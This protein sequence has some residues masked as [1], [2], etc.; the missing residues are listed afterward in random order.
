MIGLVSACATT[1][2]PDVMEKWH[3]SYRHRFHDYHVGFLPGASSPLPPGW[4]LENLLVRKDR[5]LGPTKPGSEYRH[6]VR[7]D[8]DGDGEFEE[9][10]DVLTYDLL[11]KHDKHNGRIW[12]STVALPGT[13][14]ER[15]LSVLTRDYLES[16]ST[17]GP[18]SIGLDKAMR[19][20]DDKVYAT[21]IRGQARTRIDGRQARSVLFDV[22]NAE[23]VRLANDTRW[24]RV[25]VV[26]VRP[27]FAWTNRRVSG[28]SS[29]RDAKTDVPFYP[30]VLVAGYANDSSE[31]RRGQADFEAFIDRL[32]IGPLVDL[33][34]MRDAVLEC[35]PSAKRI[36][37]EILVD[38][39]GRPAAIAEHPSST[40]VVT[41]CMK[42]ALASYEFPETGSVRT[43]VHTF[44]R[45]RRVKPK[46]IRKLAVSEKPPKKKKTPKK[47]DER[48]SQS[49]RAIEHNP[50]SHNPYKD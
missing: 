32:K 2:S 46:R 34:P 8:P 20:P 50:Y 41:D 28:S 19:L 47:A 5:R 45:A 22:A 18:V 44:D 43:Y 33:S 11:F 42:E 24:E 15:S 40:D 48:P 23:A 3:A 4:R 31:F 35:E 36:L 14:R 39:Q 26:L 1:K 10:A 6:G 9:S 38:A 49:T 37:V 25:K 7:L 29:V 16:V 17:T 21:R 13:M 30:V 12:V 27:P